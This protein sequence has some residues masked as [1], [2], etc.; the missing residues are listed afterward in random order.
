MGIEWLPFHLF[1]DIG[2]P[3]CLAVQIGMINLEN[4]P[5]KNNFGA[6]TGPRNNGFTS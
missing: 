2:Q 3:V 1:D 5:G 6:F 4:V